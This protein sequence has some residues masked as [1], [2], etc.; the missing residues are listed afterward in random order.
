MRDDKYILEIDHVS[1]SFPGVKALK[2]I[3]LKVEKGKILGLIGENGAGKSTLMKILSG[4]Y[5]KES[6]EIYFKGELVKDD[7]TSLESQ[8]LGISIIF[9]EFN[10]IPH[11]SVTENIY[12]NRLNENEKGLFINWNKLRKRAQQLLKDVGYNIDVRKTVEELGVSEKQM[13]EIIKALSYNAELIIMDEPSATLTANELNTFFEVIK[14]LKRQNIT[15]IYIT[16]KLE[17]IFQICDN[18]T[19]LRDGEVID[20][21]PVRT[22]EGTITKEE[23]INKMVG[24]DLKEEYPER[25]QNIG[26]EILRVEGLSTTEKLKNISFSLHEGEILGIVGLVGAGKTETVRAIF[27]ADKR[28]GGDIYFQG[29]KISIH[30]PSDAIRNSIILLTEDRKQQGLFLKYSIKLNIPAM[31]IKKVIKKRLISYKEE[32]KYC[33]EYIEL[34]NI[35]TP[36]E[37]Q[38]ALFLSG[39]N[40]QKVVVAKS[41]FANPKVLMMDEPTR[42]IDVG[43]KYEIYCNMN[44]LVENGKAIIFISSELAEVLAMSDRVL[45]LYN[46]ALFGEFSSEEFSKPEHILKKIIGQ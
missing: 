6:G 20:T 10:L 31:N 19:V 30:R 11:L 18:V 44:N 7:L 24:R 43:A 14:E 17:E 36:S 37:E 45:V 8:K 13:V 25:I 33:K 39:G 34:L 42:G 40:Q 26:D 35:K 1:K 12:L 28:N 21:M 9:Q 29:K 4:V 46:G 5:Q 23:I 38:P 2:D 22:N 27:G 41:L 3:S 16:H 15:I 32:S